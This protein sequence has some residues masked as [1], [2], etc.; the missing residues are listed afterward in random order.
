MS[1]LSKS[2]SLNSTEVQELSVDD[3]EDF[4]DDDDAE[5]VDSLRVSRR[6]PNDAADLVLGLPSFTTGNHG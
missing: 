1:S 2:Q 6:N 4:E 3:I 5:E